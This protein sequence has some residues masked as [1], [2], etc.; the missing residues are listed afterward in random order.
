MPQ[1]VDAVT[2]TG[3]A[4]DLVIDLNGHQGFSLSGDR[5]SLNDLTITKGVANQGGGLNIS[6]GEVIQLTD[7]TIRGNRAV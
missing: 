5:I 1:I 7:V 6:A 3:P 4:N 2:I